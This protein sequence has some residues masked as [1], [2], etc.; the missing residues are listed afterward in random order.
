MHVAP[1][2]LK[3]GLVRAFHSFFIVLGFLVTSCGAQKVVVLRPPRALGSDVLAHQ[4]LHVI[5]SIDEAADPLPL[6]GNS[7]VFAGVANA[8]GDAVSTA[9][10]PW[11][12]RHSGD[13]P[14]GWE[15]RVALIQSRA[16]VSGGRITVELAA[17][18]TLS[19]L[20][21]QVYLAQTH[22]YCRQTDVLGEVPT[23][24]VYACMDGM[25]HDLA[26]WLEGVPP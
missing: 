17:S 22:G 4:P 9:T 23:A 1:L 12:A 20:I 8:L 11:G 19:A 14:G 16:E 5:A 21:G 10:A 18:V 26:G 3:A 24:T 7:L 13:R 25:A 6:R 2:L 15:L